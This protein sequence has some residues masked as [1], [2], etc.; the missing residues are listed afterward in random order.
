MT[1]TYRERSEIP[2]SA[3][4]IVSYPERFLWQFLK[5]SWASQMQLY[6][7]LLQTYSYTN[8]WE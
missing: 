6:I 5:T 7:F 4:L 2:V 1:N 8:F 3:V